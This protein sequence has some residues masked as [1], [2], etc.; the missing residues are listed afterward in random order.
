VIVEILVAAALTKPQYQAL[1]ERA[2]R[3][4]TAAETAA[5][6]G[7]TPR[8]KPAKIATLLDGMAAAEAA[9]ARMFASAAP[10]ANARAVT[11]LLVRG[12]RTYATELHAAANQVRTTADPAAYVR[13]LF[14]GGGPKVGPRLVDRAL[15]QLKRLGYQVG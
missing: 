4:V 7:I 15:A 2:D 6:R 9:N 10:P 13:R 12:E 11:A 1:L 3:R 8:T 5:E 14:S